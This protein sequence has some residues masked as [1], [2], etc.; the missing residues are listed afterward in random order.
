MPARMGDDDHPRIQRPVQRRQTEPDPQVDHRKDST[1]DLD[2]TCDVRRAARH[3]GGP[4]EALH[5]QDIARR[6]DIVSVPHPEPHVQQGYSL[7]RHTFFA[8]SPRAASDREPRWAKSS[9]SSTSVG[10]PSPRSV[11][12][13][14]PST[15]TKGSPSG[16][17]TTSCRPIILSTS[18]ASRSLSRRIRM[19]FELRRSAFAKPSSELK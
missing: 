10:W 15:L 7:F 8:C 3:L 16:R 14:M 17:T 13:V 19:A 2:E 18:K 4:V 1:A 12:P 9:R 6:Q 11:L 5:L